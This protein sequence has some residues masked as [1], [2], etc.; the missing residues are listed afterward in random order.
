[1][2]SVSPAR[3]ARVPSASATPGPDCG[4]MPAVS[5]SANSNFIVGIGE[6][7]VRFTPRG[8]EG[9]AGRRPILREGRL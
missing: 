7:P 3:L 4:I 6:M 1:M 9:L 5:P 8:P 2:T